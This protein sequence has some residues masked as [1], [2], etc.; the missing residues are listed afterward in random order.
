MNKYKDFTVED[1][2]LD[3]YFRQWALGE[4]PETD[5]FWQEFQLMHLDKMKSIDWKFWEQRGKNSRGTALLRQTA[6][7][8]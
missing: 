1:F 3:K 4:L 5:T 2:V 8:K 7:I 6:T